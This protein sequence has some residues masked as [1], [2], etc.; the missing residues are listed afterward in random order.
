M[1][2]KVLDA[3]GNLAQSEAYKLEASISGGGL[4]VPENT[5]SVSKNIIEGY[6]SFDVTN[7]Q[8]ADMNVSFRISRPGTSLSSDPLRLRSIDFAKISVEI[9]GK[10]AIVV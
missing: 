8:S 3:F 9:D 4:F 10:D 7:S 1:V 2:V 6:T 5:A